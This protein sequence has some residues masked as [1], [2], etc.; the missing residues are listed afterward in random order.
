MI[1]ANGCSHTAHLLGPGMENKRWPNIVGELLGDN[2]VINLAKGGDSNGTI[3]DSTIHWLET[4][5]IKPD[6]VIIQWTYADRFDIP[7][8]RKYADNPFNDG[9]EWSYPRE[10][11][12]KITSTRFYE[13]PN[14]DTGMLEKVPDLINHIGMKFPDILW[15]AANKQNTHPYYLKKDDDPHTQEVIDF[16]KR[17]V[18]YREAFCNLPTTKEICKENWAKA[19][20]Y[21]ASY[22]ETRDI[23]YYWWT[24]ECW[25]DA[26]MA[27]YYYLKPKVGNEMFG[28]IMRIEFWLEKQGIM[29]CGNII[30]VFHESE[31]AVTQVID[32]HRGE[33]GHKYIGEMIAKYILTGENPDPNAEDRKHIKEILESR[34][35][36]RSKTIKHDRIFDVED[37]DPRFDL[38]W[39][40][41]TDP[42]YILPDWWWCSI[43]LGNFYYE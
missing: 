18:D 33:D 6:Y 34:P 41:A 7:Y 9:R 13:A 42:D 17:Y 15:K 36:L 27:D 16:Y 4:N 26:S 29:S 23:N 8:H 3:A 24:T 19:Q 5:T 32:D 25:H 39:K 14:S 30:N 12:N 40:F 28:N 21:L 20:H 11:Q 22:L 1:L 31:D 35:N 2:N 10:C 37:Y 38:L 43:N